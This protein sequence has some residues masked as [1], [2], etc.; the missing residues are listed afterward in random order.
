MKKIHA[1]FLFILVQCFLTVSGQVTFDRGYIIDNSGIKTKCLIKNY[2]W[3]SNPGAI[4][5]KLL[6]GS[7][8][9]SVSIDSIREFEVENYSRFLRAT[10]KI[11]RSPTEL[12]LL[13]TTSAP[14]WSEETLF[15]RELV[16][17]K[18]CLWVYTNGQSWFFYSLDGSQPEQLVYKK[19]RLEE[20]YSKGKYMVHENTGFRQQL[21]TYL[22]NEN[23][24]G[25][26][27]MNLEYRETSLVKYFKRYNS[28]YEENTPAE[29]KKP[30]REVLNLKI[31]GSLNYGRLN[32]ENALM[33]YGPRKYDFGSKT[34]WMGGLELE[35][36]LP[37]N[38][39]TVSI[40]FAPTFEHYT[41]SK[42]I[43]D[44][45]IS[46][47]MVSVHFPFG[48]R[49]G[50]FLNDDMKFFFDVCYNPFVYINKNDGF[51]LANHVTLD[52]KEA[53]SWI[54]GVGFAYKKWQIEFQYHTNRYLLNE[55]PAWETEYAKVALSISYKFFNVR[56]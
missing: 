35:Y 14:L 26:N 56:K 9:V 51:T 27:L 49:Y 52:I 55:Y 32:I 37:F 43:Y 4:Q 33:T 25:V 29:V 34:N 1:I 12:G 8:V 39:N 30:E 16:C 31:T 23:T 42:I 6:E 11:D 46:I 28:L 54:L 18:A 44:S 24:K 47:D 22:K 21:Y 40:L 13:S 36:F 10:V 5:Y 48:V 53:D 41:N 15:L 45:P 17:G 7:P 50:L 19:Y 38:R 3:K 2:D 20:E